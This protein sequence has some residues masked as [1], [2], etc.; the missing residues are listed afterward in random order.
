MPRLAVSTR[1]RVITLRR[2]GYGLKEIQRRLNEEGIVISVR[3]LQRLCAKFEK[4]HTIQDL[5]RA[6]KHRMLTPQ[7]LSAMDESLSNDDEL[8][9]RKLKARLRE[10][11]T[12]LPDVSLSTIK[13]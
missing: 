8:T 2:Q 5:P 11:F 12:E 3:S 7:M 13:R 10:Q 6:F 4:M 9:A 1:K